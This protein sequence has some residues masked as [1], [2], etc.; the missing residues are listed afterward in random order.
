[1]DRKSGE[2]LQLG[3]LEDTREDRQTR[4]G[5]S[6]ECPH[7]EPEEGPFRELPKKS[8]VATEGI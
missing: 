7:K 6:S 5:G 2:V 4:E 8:Q 1:M 3:A